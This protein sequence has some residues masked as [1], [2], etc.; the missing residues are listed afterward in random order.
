VPLTPGGPLPL[1]VLVMEGGPV[2]VHGDDGG[3]GELRI[4]LSAGGEEQETQ[5]V[6]AEPGP[7]ALLHGPVSRQGHGGGP[8]DAVHLPGRLDGPGVIQPVHQVAGIAGPGRQA[9]PPPLDRIPQPGQPRPAPGQ[10]TA[11]VAAFLHHPQVQVALPGTPGHRRGLV[12][13]VLGLVDQEQGPVTRPEQEGRAGVG[14]QGRPLEEEGFGPVG[15]ILVVPEHRDGQAGAD[16]DAVEARFRQ[17]GGIALPDLVQVTGI[18]AVAAHGA[19][20]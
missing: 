14:R 4:G 8:P 3:V 11:Q 7:E 1:A 19:E 15:M 5:F 9:E 10:V 16:H 20:L 12:P 17:G 13:V 18:V 6:L 2:P